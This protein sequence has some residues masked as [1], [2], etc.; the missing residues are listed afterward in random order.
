MEI[1]RALFIIAAAAGPCMF[2][3][4]SAGTARV[5]KPGSPAAY[6][7]PEIKKDRSSCHTPDGSSRGE[8]KNALSRFA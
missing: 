3:A 7:H 8:L 5:R 1:R 2:P 4:V 6:P